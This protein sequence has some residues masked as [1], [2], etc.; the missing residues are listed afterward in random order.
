M[1]RLG[2]L[3]ALTVALCV[4]AA[5]VSCGTDPSLPSEAETART[6]SKQYEALK[7]EEIVRHAANDH[8]T[9]TSYSWVGTGTV[10][11][12]DLKVVGSVDI[13]GSC[14]TKV[15]IGEQKL[16]IRHPKG[17]PWFSRGN[18]E[19]MAQLLGAGASQ[20]VERYADQWLRVPPPESDD[21]FGFECDLKRRLAQADQFALGPG[22]AD[23]CVKKADVIDGE[24]AVS[25]RCGKEWRWIRVE[26]PHYLLRTAT[27][28]D[29]DEASEVR[30]SNFNERVDVDVPAGPVIDLT[31]GGS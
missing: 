6:S 12:Q 14:T 21:A 16:E 5:A 13:D 25:I 4:S 18:A 19:A 22:E 2:G 23:A 27:L 8:S 28:G 3:A 11:D 9:L 17:G 10:D 30:L 31:G 26:E 24:A 7:I 20:T 15:S 29:G 1:S